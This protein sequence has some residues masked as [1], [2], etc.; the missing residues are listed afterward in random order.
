MYREGRLSDYYN[1]EREVLEHFKFKD[2]CFRRGK[3]VYISFVPE[4]MIRRMYKKE[5]IKSTVAVQNKVRKKGLKARFSDIRETHTTYSTKYLKGNEIDF[6][7]GRATR[8]IFMKNYFNPDLI[9]D[10]KTRFNRVIDEIQERPKLGC[11]S[12]PVIN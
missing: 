8:N 5:P 2:I 11:I 4:S 9:K 6:L 1:S 3:K 7:H 10:L 12:L